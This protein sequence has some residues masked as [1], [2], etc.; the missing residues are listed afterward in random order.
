M[1][2]GEVDV[3]FDIGAA[4]VGPLKPDGGGEIDGVFGI[5]GLRGG[6]GG[7]KD[8]E[9]VGFGVDE[10]GDVLFEG[11]GLETKAFFEGVLRQGVVAEGFDDDDFEF[12]GEDGGHRGALVGGV[13]GEA[14]LEGEDVG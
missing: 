6:D 14:I 10:L 13:V 11:V 8:D 4:F 1:F 3:V 2:E 12:P 5:V 7:Q 9:G